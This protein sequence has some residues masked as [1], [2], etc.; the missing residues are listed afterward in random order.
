[1][2]ATLPEV[3]ARFAA[4]LLLIL[5]CAVPAVGAAESHESPEQVERHDWRWF[6]GYGLLAGLL[7]G[8]VWLLQ[9]R[10]VTLEA[11]YSRRLEQAV[12]QR[13]HELAERNDA[14]ARA[15]SGL[16][17]ASLT[18]PL[19]GL[20]NRRF[21]FEEVTR[22]VELIK[23]WHDDHDDSSSETFNIFFVIVD[24]DF[25]KPVNDRCGHAAGDR[26]L[27]Q[28]RDVLLRSVR[29]SDVVVRWG[30]DEFVVLSNNVK[31]DQI[32]SLA[33]RI[34]SEIAG[35]VFRLDEAQVVRTTCSIG[36]AGYPFVN[37]TP[38]A[39][40]WEQVL[41]LAD[42]ALYLAKEQRDCWVGYLGN[43]QAES[44]DTLFNA[45]RKD[46]LTAEDRG[47]VR[48]RASVPLRVREG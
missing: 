7:A 44:P 48:I 28:V 12:R 20:R 35:E 21:L 23:R 41:G 30:G 14:L 39:I 4:L 25:F 3:P 24:L 16:L 8:G 34:R 46:P 27:L 29:S 13:T 17:E 1:M 2:S 31:A 5:V 15:N 9:Q 38:D 18:D 11:E 32:E 45:I 40:T 19:T 6:A 22:H 43:D 36:Y 33:E 26:M 42:S 10:K 47:G 37:A